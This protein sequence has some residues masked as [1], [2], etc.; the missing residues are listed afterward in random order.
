MLDKIIPPLCVRVRF[1][2]ALATLAVAVPRLPVFDA[3][4]VA[5]LGFFVPSVYAYLLL[6]LGLALVVTSYRWRLHWVGRL[7]ALLGFVAWVTLVFAASSVTSI[8]INAIMA[9]VLFTEILAHHDC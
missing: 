8:A 2:A 5:Q 7:V 1:V 6:P 4:I 3:L 9:G